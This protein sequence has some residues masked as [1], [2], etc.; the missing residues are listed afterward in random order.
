MGQLFQSAFSFNYIK[1]CLIILNAFFY[2]KILVMKTLKTLIIAALEKRNSQLA[3]LGM[4][5]I[6]INSAYSNCNK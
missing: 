5:V 4:N 3:S 6:L 1:Y 2:I